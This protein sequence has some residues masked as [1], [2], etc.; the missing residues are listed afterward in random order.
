[1]KLAITATGKTL[2][3]DMD[4]RF[5]RCTYFIV[6]DSEYNNHEI[7]ENPHKDDA[8]GAGPAA[9]Q[10]IAAKGVKKIISGHFGDKAKNILQNLQIEMEEN[11]EGGTIES[12]ITNIKS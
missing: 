9:A 5:G 6:Y 8:G 3:S 4:T 2:Q 12:I 7:Y 11:H 10:F 1:M